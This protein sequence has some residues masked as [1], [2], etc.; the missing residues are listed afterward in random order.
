M[1]S[2]EMVGYIWLASLLNEIWKFPLCRLRNF[3]VE[4]AKNEERRN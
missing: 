4:N 2:P 3:V 1:S